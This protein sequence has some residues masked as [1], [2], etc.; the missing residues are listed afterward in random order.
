MSKITNIDFG[1]FDLD[2]PLGE[3]STNGHQATLDEFRRRAGNKTL[4]EAATG[5]YSTNL[6]GTA[7]HVAGMMA[8]MMEQV[9]GDGFLFSM[10]NVTRRT[11][12]EIT[13]GLVPALQQRGL[14]RKEYG[15]EQFRENLLE[16]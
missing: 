10:P 4:R 2:A 7:D 13:D 9:G 3:V 8:E 6:V 11:V 16:F 5:Y 12:A 14:V 15:F 1:A